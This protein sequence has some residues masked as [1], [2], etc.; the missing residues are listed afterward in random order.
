MENLRAERLRREKEERAKAEKLLAK[1]KGEN[2]DEPSAVSVPPPDG[3]Q[4]YNSQFNPHLARK[5]KS[6]N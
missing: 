2:V 1:L 6:D 5:P 4:G 3:K